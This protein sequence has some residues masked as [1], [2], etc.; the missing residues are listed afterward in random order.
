MKFAPE[1]LRVVI[2]GYRRRFGLQHF[3]AKHSQLG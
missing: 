2:Y 1:N 3:E